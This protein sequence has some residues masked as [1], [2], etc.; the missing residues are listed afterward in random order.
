MKDK[1]LFWL[2]NHAVHFGI[3][4][5]IADK[6]DCES[7]ALI[8]CSPIQRKF[9]N[10]QKLIDFKKKWFVRDNIDLKKDEPDFEKLKYLEKKFS[11]QLQKIVYADRSFYKY[12]NYHKFSD[13]EIFSIIEQELILYDKILDEIKPDF[14]IMRTPEFQDI[15]LFCEV[16]KAKK[17][18]LL[19]LTSARIGNRYTITSDPNSPILFDKSNNKIE[20]KSFSDLKKY[21]E[22]FSQEHKKFLKE[23]QV[24]KS[25]KINI[26]KTVFS[27]YNSSNINSYRDVGKTSWTTLING[28]TRF[29]KSK[30]RK[31]FLDK[32][33]KMFF[34]T[35]RP[36]A[37]F[38]LHMEPER[39]LLKKAQFYSDQLSVIKNVIQSLPV[40]MDLIVKEH[41]SMQLIGWR[42]VE[43]YKE[44]M[45]LPKVRLIHPFVQNQD[46][47]E[48][49]S[50]VVAI[51]GTA[52]LE[53]AFFEKPS[54]V[55]SD[56][57]CSSL[58]SVFKID[59]VEEL[60]EIIKKSL[61][62]KVNLVE[63]NQ[64]VH[65][66][67]KSS[68]SSDVSKLQNKMIQIFGIGGYFIGNEISEVQM[69]TFI[70]KYKNSFEILAEEHIKQIK[71][72]KNNDLSSN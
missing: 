32:N 24:K 70:E 1:I 28:L 50:L 52:A 42:K 56:V 41:P 25:N 65:E 4:K 23:A 22:E 20:N 64:F 8:A 57:D 59:N 18:S 58:S 45:S 67:I 54:I 5:A 51:A 43:F 26:L 35:K 48:R 10:E 27:T 40:E 60:P 31:S 68:F 2:E 36:Y 72:I 9:F 12:N 14:I 30:Y 53:A 46:I 47:I 15:D 39:S 44:L 71:L 3:A 33:A 6:Y 13:G 19:L 7:Y 69:N 34:V 63:L 21:V 62:T 11:I 38:P 55:F 29:L 17:I 49:S 66:V 61:D 37:Y 16:C